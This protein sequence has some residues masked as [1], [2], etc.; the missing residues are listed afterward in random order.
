MP[1]PQTRE[2]LIPAGYR[3]DN[4]AICRGCKEDIEWWFTPKG[5]KMP[6]NLM[7]KDDSPAV[8]HWSTCPNADDFRSGGR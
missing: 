7:Q 4:H 8:P 6:F 1:F 2:A 5:R 3:F